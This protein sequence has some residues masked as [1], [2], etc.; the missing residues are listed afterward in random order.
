[1]SSTIKEIS[2]MEQEKLACD[3]FCVSHYDFLLYSAL[4]NPYNSAAIISTLKQNESLR[5]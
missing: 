4:L 2:I 1:M 3:A 5:R